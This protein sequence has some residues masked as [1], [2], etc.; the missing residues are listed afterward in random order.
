MSG[1]QSYPQA[2]DLEDSL[3]RVSLKAIIRNE[4]DEFL[5]VKEAGRS[6]WDLP[7]GGM[8]MNENIKI[9]L[10]RELK[11][12]VGLSGD[13]SFR[14]VAIEDPRDLPH[15][16]FKQIR[17]IFEFKPD[18]DHFEVSTDS[19][20]VRFMDPKLFTQSIHYSEQK[21]YEYSK[22]VS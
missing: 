16:K 2:S 21:I 20:E 14:I 17:V 7:G 8:E 5:V 18:S 13:F 4:A 10:A 1:P 15:K 22:L 12:E 11:E 3:F 19:D 6:N 9:A